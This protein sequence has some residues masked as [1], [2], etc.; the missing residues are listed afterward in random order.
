LPREGASADRVLHEDSSSLTI[1]SWRLGWACGGLRTEYQ[2]ED[3]GQR[4]LRP[5]VLLLST[6]TQPAVALSAND[7]LARGT[8][9]QSTVCSNAELD[10]SGEKLPYTTS[11][12]SIEPDSDDCRHQT[13]HNIRVAFHSS[14]PR[15]L[16]R[17][18][19]GRGRDR[20]CRGS[21]LGG[22]RSREPP[23]EETYILGGSIRASE[24]IRSQCS[25]P[26]R[27]GRDTYET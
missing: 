11:I 3:T 6:G 1:A 18:L 27:A 5:H 13:P 4:L 22:G 9:I 20:G 23:Q 17:S 16:T 14:A 19:F 24:F 12:E 25:S 8:T 7:T 10:I 26:I 2:V 21:D 15:G